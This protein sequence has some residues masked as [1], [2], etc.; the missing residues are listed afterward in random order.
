M[1]VDRRCV[2]TSAIVLRSPASALFCTPALVS[3]QAEQ[4]FAPCG[5][6]CAMTRIRCAAG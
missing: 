5:V 2:S 4:A 6:L 1:T 3:W